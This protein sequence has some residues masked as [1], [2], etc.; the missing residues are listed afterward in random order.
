M[1]ICLYGASS[2]AIAKSYINP[3]EA[4]GAKIAD[5]GHTLIYG[6]GAAGLMGAAARGAYSR[7]GKIIGVVPSFLNV[8][9]ILFD[10][11]DELIFTETMRQRKQLMEQRSDAFIMTPGGLGTFDEFFEILTLKQLGRHSKP[12]AVFN[13]NGY[14]DSLIA[15]LKNAVHKQ[16]MTLEALELCLFT[17][18]EDKL[19]NYLEDGA[20]AQTQARIFKNLK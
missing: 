19:L 13:I 1:N 15:Q 18:N 14:F 12:I 9:G 2:S 8:D 16:F 3:T 4:L 10:K 17:D 6:G 5:R 11:C 7:S 20:H